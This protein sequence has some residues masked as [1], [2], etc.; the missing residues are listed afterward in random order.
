MSI[1]GVIVLWS[2]SICLR[3]G[4]LLLEGG[5]FYTGHMSSNKLVHPLL[6]GKLGDHC[7]LVLFV[8]NVGPSRIR[9]G[10]GHSTL[11]QNDLGIILSR[12]HSTL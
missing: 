1:F 6:E 8:S 10:E 9:R 12:S 11:R 4:H 2:W 7:L 3:G 5:S